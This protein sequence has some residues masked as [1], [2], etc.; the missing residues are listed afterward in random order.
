MACRFKSIE[1][2]ASFFAR[3]IIMTLYNVRS[4]PW[5]GEKKYHFIAKRIAITTQGI[6]NKNPIK[7]RTPAVWARLTVIPIHFNR[8][9]TNILESFLEK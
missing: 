1:F 4:I 3:D 7:R 6:P 8:F 5:L 9:G 2:K